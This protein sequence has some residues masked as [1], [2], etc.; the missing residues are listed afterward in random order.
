MSNALDTFVANW[1]SDSLETGY[2][3]AG[4]GTLVDE[5]FAR[6]F[7]LSEASQ[8]HGL[9]VSSLGSYGMV[10]ALKVVAWKQYRR[11]LRE[12]PSIGRKADVF[13]TGDVIE[14]RLLAV[15]ESSGLTVTHKQDELMWH[16]V[17][18]HPDG[19]VENTVFDVKT[20]SSGN[21]KRFLKNP[22]LTYVTQLSVYAQ[23][24]N[25][26]NAALLFYDK[27]NCKLGL[28]YLDFDVMEDARTRASEIIEG[29]NACVT[30]AD[31][32]DV[33]DVPDPLE[34][35]FQK[36]GTG[37]YYAPYDLY[38]PFP[39]LLYERVTDKSGYDNEREYIIGI[40]SPED[41]AMLIK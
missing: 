40:R 32:Y 26:S 30:I 15:M 25:A 29:V 35:I 1:N 33:F 14:A 34:E 9:R 31:V 12:K 24:L 28:K 10:Q 11:S 4:Y 21:F 39:D 19:M 5:S 6:N 17:T 18:G 16:G 13:H 20:S 41:V 27:D 38:P 8:S 37:K 36:K 7:Q 23:A 3:S 2:Y 22:P